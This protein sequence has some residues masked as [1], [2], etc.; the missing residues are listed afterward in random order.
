MQKLLIKNIKEYSF[1]DISKSLTI[2]KIEKFYLK[3]M[4]NEFSY[5]IE[6]ERLALDKETL[7]NASYEKVSKIIK[8][9]ASILNWNLIYDEETII[10]AYDDKNNSISLEPGQQLEL[11]IRPY[12]N[13][14]DIEQFAK[15]TLNLLDNIASIYNVIFLGYGITPTSKVNDITLLNKRRY[16]VMNDYLPKCLNAELCPKMMRKTAGIQINIDFKNKKDCY[17]K[18]EF[19]N[20]IMPFISALF[21]N[22]PLENDIISQ[23]KS[24]RAHI[25]Q[26]TGTQRCNLFYKNVFN[27][28]FFKHQNVFK[29]YIDAILDVPMVYIER[30]NEYI[31]IKGK[32][33]FREF[34]EIGYKGYFPTIEDYILHQSLCFPDVRLKNYIEIRNHDSSSLSNVL[35]L[36]ALYKGLSLSN[37]DKLLKQFD[38]IDLNKIDYYFEKTIIDGLNFKI[39]NITG[40]DIVSKLF[41]ISKNNLNSKERIYLKP[42]FEMI[43]KRKTQSEKIIELG[44]KNSKELVDFLMD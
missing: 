2:Q 36:C 13:I 6:Y 15:K 33:T 16:K 17:Q 28:K 40:W 42:I 4:K 5:G 3:G 32:L 38:F 37:F 44:I 34:M 27:K 30:N 43:K 39:N 11:S 35:A 22:S 25:W 41:T 8:D 18:L 29:N 1:P 21:A 19:F 7:E 23:Y 20:K 9:F 12:K 24:T 14:K 26:H 31:E 10:G